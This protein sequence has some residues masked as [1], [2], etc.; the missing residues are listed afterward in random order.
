VTVCILSCKDNSK[1]GR[2]LH[3]GQ[4]PSSP[5]IEAFLIKVAK[6]T[7]D[8]RAYSVA[9]F[10]HPDDLSRFRSAFGP[11]VEKMLESVDGRV[12]LWRFPK[13]KSQREKISDIE[14]F[15]LF[16]QTAHDATRAVNQD[17]PDKYDPKVIGVVT[18]GKTLHAVVRDSVRMHGKDIEK[19]RVFSLRIDQG[20]IYLTIETDLIASAEALLPN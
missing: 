7:A 12:F 2:G 18:E 20:Q 3:S 6:L 17:L 4:N 15:S 10:F 5:A 19:V 11:K 9:S 16:M 14:F 13:E 1:S 8:S